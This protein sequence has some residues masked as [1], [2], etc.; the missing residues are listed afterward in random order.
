MAGQIGRA[1]QDL[2]ISKVTMQIT[3]D[4]HLG[5]ILERETVAMP[6]RSRSYQSESLSEVDEQA[7]GCRHDDTCWIEHE[8]GQ[9]FTNN[10]EYYN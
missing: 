9:R 7:I 3:S 6:P 2:E 10:H 1:K 4:E 5:A 8:F